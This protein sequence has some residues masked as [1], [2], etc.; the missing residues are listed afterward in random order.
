MLLSRLV[1]TAAVA[2]ALAIAT[3]ARAQFLTVGPSP[4]TLGSNRENSET[5]AYRV[6]SFG[7]FGMTISEQH[8][9]YRYPT[10]ADLQPAGFF[11]V[12]AHNLARADFNGDGR[13]D[14]LVSFSLYPHTIPRQTLFTFAVLLNDGQGGFRYSTDI[15][16]PTGPPTRQY[17]VT[18]IVIA[19]FNRDGRPDFV[20][21]P[22]GLNQRNADGS[23]TTGRDPLPLALSGP[24]G[25]LYDATANIAGQENGGRVPGLDFSHEI[26]AGDLNGDGA[27]DIY[28][29]RVLL[30]N[31]G[32][33]RFTDGSSQLPTEL[34]SFSIPYIMSSTIGD[35][36]GDGIGDLVVAY[37]DGSPANASGYIWLSQNGSPS[38]A[39]RR[40][41]PLPAGRYGAGQTKFN[42][43]RI[44]D[45]TG[46]G[47]P[48]IVFGVTRADP[49]YVGRTLQILVNRGD[50][51]FVD[52][53]AS[54][55][56]APTTLDGAPGQGM[57]EIT[58]VNRDGFLDI[59]H[60]GPSV[61]NANDLPSMTVYLGG[62]DGILRAMNS[63]LLPWVQ[64]W[65]LAG[66]EDLRPY[67]SR[68]LSISYAADI[69]GRGGLDFVS[70][71]T[72]P[73]R[74]VPQVEP[75]QITF[76][77]ILSKTPDAPAPASKLSNLSVRTSAGSG[78][79][80][81]IVGFLV[82]GGSQNI[83]ARGVGPTLGAF[84]V[85]GTIT[86]PKLELYSGSIQSTANDNWASSGLL[87]G[88]FSRV[89]AFPLPA[90]S[91]DAALRVGVKGGRSLQV[92]GADG[93][94]GLA[95]VELYDAG[96]GTGRLI[97]VSARAEVGTGADTLTAGFAITGTV[98][99]RLLI[100]A[101][102]PTLGAFGVG[103]TLADPM[104]DVRPLGSDNIVANNDDWSGT[105]ALKAAFTSVGAFGFA[106]DASRDAALAVELPPGAYTATVSGK[107]G[108]TG[109]ALVEVYELP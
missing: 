93:G 66:Y 97:N 26:S 46:D 45:V 19:D 42:D 43:L 32:T 30:L 10:P 37:A 85:A 80:T 92:T 56:V 11:G 107:G 50:S 106:S 48:D 79:R 60:S 98:P 14:L 17:I 40:L 83:L 8:P 22:E 16:G 101:A 49:Y 77:S 61:T 29:A 65:Q 51:N 104:L 59:V 67:W 89:G 3:P 57:L 18:R 54:R 36:N 82:A 13:E 28:T 2:A 68:P 62:P 34:K 53:T 52:E 105:A 72:S 33:G 39:N 5:A 35:L 96:G 88:D 81:L 102:G 7:W 74:A 4:R 70:I 99:K 90:G 41:V 38:F 94:S 47:R 25:K 12:E 95:L 58:D 24:D 20:A 21:A 73:F 76:Y 100:R 23:F 103:G 69:D 71:V 6:G 109:V 44:V 84:G 63:V 78:D 91:R 27:P 31:D 15:W 9:E 87:A 55:V 1:S 86:D 108:T 75:N 64:P